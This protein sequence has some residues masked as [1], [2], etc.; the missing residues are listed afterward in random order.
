MIMANEEEGDD[1]LNI[2]FGNNDS[3]TNHNVLVYVKYQDNEFLPQFVVYYKCPKSMV[4]G[5]QY[6][7]IWWKDVS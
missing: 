6:V 4:Y 1:N 2:P 5:S 7:T 3:T